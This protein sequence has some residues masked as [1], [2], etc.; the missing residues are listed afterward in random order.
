MSTHNVRAELAG[1]SGTGT[2]GSGSTYTQTYT[3]ANRTI[4][5]ATGVAV[6][7]SGTG[8]DGGAIAAG[9]GLYT[10]TVPFTWVAGAGALDVCSA[11]VLGHKFKIMS[12]SWVD[13]GTV[14][15][16]SSGSRVANMEIGIVDVGTTPSTC[17]VVQ[18]STAPGRKIDG[19]TVTGA[20]TGS[21]T[22][23]F[24]IELA[25]SG[26]EIT[27]GNGAFLVKI[28]NMDVADAFAALAAEVVNLIADDLD[29][30]QSVTALIDDL[31]TVEVVD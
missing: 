30:R 31:Q 7:D 15:V 26:T 8:T 5:N 6:T 11:Y 25:A 12:W 14:L 24:S 27:A 16:G 19:T 22:D 1:A 21:A 23:T 29:N 9:V 2:S 20:N 17:T 18:A 10:L 4:A 3:T 28:Q 13:G